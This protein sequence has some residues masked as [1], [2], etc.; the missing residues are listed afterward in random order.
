MPSSTSSNW[1]SMVNAS[2]NPAVF[3]GGSPGGDGGGRFG[4]N[5]FY[6]REIAEGVRGPIGEYVGPLSGTEQTY[7]R[8]EERIREEERN[9]IAAKVP[10]TTASTSQSVDA[11]LVS[12]NKDSN[13]TL[14]DSLDRIEEV[15]EGIQTTNRNQVALNETESQNLVYTQQMAQ[16]IQQL[17]QYQQQR[18]NLEM[19]FLGQVSND[20]SKAIYKSFSIYRVNTNIYISPGMGETIDFSI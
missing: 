12:L 19:Q 5:P 6:N 9:R 16:G 8:N 4:L 20:I 11:T 17:N 14:N 2:Y 18:K 10:S 15:A 1:P 13:Q 3:Y 7:I